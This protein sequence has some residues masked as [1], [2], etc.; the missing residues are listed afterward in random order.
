MSSSFLHFSLHYITTERVNSQLKSIVRPM[1][2]NPPV[3]GARIVTEILSD[4]VLK[5]QWSVECKGR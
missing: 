2:S 1:Y 5:K 4:P 3:Y